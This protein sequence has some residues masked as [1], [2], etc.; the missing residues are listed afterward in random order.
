MGDVAQILKGTNIDEDVPNKSMKMLGLPKDVMQI[1]AGKQDPLSAALPPIVPTFTSAST[2]KGT[3]S[4]D[5][6]TV[7]VGNKMISSSKPARPW[8]W[9]PFCSSSRTDGALFSHWVRANVEYT[10]YPYAKFDIHLDPVSYTDD[11]YE[12]LLKNDGWTKSETDKL[13]DLCRIY[14]LRW[15]VIHDRWIEFYDSS[16]SEQ[17]ENM[18]TTTPLRRVTDLQERYYSVA[19]TLA[20]ARIRQEAVVEVQTLTNA[21]YDPNVQNTPEKVD[22][23]LLETAAARALATAAP[24]AQPLIPNLGTGSTNKSFDA[25]SERERTMQIDRMWRRSKEEEQEEMDLRRELRDI[26]AQLRKLKKLGGHV[27]AAAGNRI[28]TSGG[29]SSSTSAAAAG[30]LTS[31]SVTP[32]PGSTIVDNPEL[33]EQSFSSTAPQPMAQNPY[34][35]SGRFIPPAAG[36]SSGINK[37]LL[38]RMQQVLTEL[39]IP[40]RPLPTK[41]VCDLYDAVRKDILTLIT[42]Q[43]MVLQKEGTLQTKRV[44]L[45]KLGVGGAGAGG[46]V[47]DEEEL[48]GITPPPPPPAPAPA[49]VPKKSAKSSTTT[50]T[51]TTAAAT[52]AATTTTATTSSSTT[53]IGKAKSTPGG[54]KAKGGDETKDG[55]KKTTTKRKRKSDGKE[56][57]AAAAAAKNSNPPA[58]GGEGTTPSPPKSSTTTTVPVVKAPPPVAGGGP[59][60]ATTTAAATTTTTTTSADTPKT[61]T[62]TTSTSTTTKAVIPPGTVATSQDSKSDSKTDSSGKKRARKS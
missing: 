39:K 13:L 60:P 58:T 59:S 3:S 44:K 46:T 32:I 2:N 26:D 21:Q 40:T 36:G 45:S 49:S 61:S 37:T 33:L 4:K 11:D 54:T 53:G 30:R 18:S 5:D 48:L 9:A 57:T 7:K 41:Q 52:A 28:A 20:Q 22:Q 17:H 23:N 24:T 16:S 14:E 8:T 62:T 29:I 43:K 50:A 6:I 31:R 25:L 42:L 1:L 38:V 12:V 19:A 55:E 27:L 15:P 51:T 35:Q 47:L 56:T 10:D 34:L